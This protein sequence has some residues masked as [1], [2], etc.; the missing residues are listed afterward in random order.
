[1]SVAEIKNNLHRMVVETDDPEIL[2]QIAAL[3]ASLLG[4]QD[5]WD[6]LSNEEKKKIER[7]EAD[8][9]AGRTAPYSQV[10]E[11]VKDILGNL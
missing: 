10:K 5:W 3:F 1:M 8:A 11:R 7:G 2:A 9:E 6:F 4:E